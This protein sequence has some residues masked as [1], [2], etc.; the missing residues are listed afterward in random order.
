[1]RYSFCFPSKNIK[2]RRKVWH[3]PRITANRKTVCWVFKSSTP[4]FW[5]KLSGGSQYPISHSTEPI[6]RYTFNY[7]LNL[8]DTVIPVNDF[9]ANCLV[10]LFVCLHVF[11]SFLLINKFQPIVWKRSIL[12][13]LKLIFSVFFVFSF[14]F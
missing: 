5:S 12:H 10:C 2:K 8:S 11:F 1:M 6:I 4:S 3:W 13:A 14:S 7:V 9:S